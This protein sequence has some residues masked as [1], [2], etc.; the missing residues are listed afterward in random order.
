MAPIDSFF[1][2][3]TMQALEVI[4]FQASTAPQVAEVLRVDA[5]TARRLLNRLTA[6]GWLVR[7]DGRVKT[8]TLSLR[9]VALASH[10]LEHSPLTDAATTVVRALHEQAGG[11]AHVVVPCYRSVL[12]LA[13]R[14]G[15]CVARPHAREL[16]Q[17]HASA[18]G[19]VLLAHR[20]PWRESVLEL[21][22]DRVTDRTVADADALRAECEVTLE[23]GYALEDGEYRDGVQ[24]VAAPVAGESGDVMAAV[25]LTGP[26]DMD[27]AAR[28]DAVL[29]AARTLSRI[30]AEEPLA[31]A[32]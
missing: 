4:A 17:A 31:R 2:V 6:E 11:V 12:C 10:F 5:R 16:I 21:P 30:L 23:R 25:A 8:Y 19:K 3:R 15:D 32:A 20:A 28:L 27:V 26:R 22:L 13:Q 24:S 1:V 14:A 18:G 29:D 9:L 7:I